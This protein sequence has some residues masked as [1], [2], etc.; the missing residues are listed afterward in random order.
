MIKNVLR[1]FIDSSDSTKHIDIFS[2]LVTQ[3]PKHSLLDSLYIYRH[4]KNQYGYILQDKNTQKIIAIDCG[5]YKTQRFNIE[6]LM[7]ETGG[8]FTHLFFTSKNSVRSEG[9]YD[10]LKVHPRLNIIKAGS[11]EDGHIEFIGD[12]CIF[13]M[14]T[15]GQNDLDTSYVI[16]EGNEGSTKTPAVFT[17][18][19]LQTGGCGKFLNPTLMYESLKKLKSLPNE[20][21][22]FPSVESAAENLMFSKIIDP[23]NE[24]VKSKL[25]EVK[26]QKRKNIGQVLCQERLYNPFLRCDQKYFLD[27]FEVKDPISC[28]TKMNKMK[29]KIL[30]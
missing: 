7:K 5:D 22:I 10:W 28:L 11:K 18:D 19:V 3:V 25:E 2:A 12:L 14:R 24:F 30:A 21:L 1:K 27:L 4:N 8:A 13:C 26:E 29:E 20:T 9:T 6:A 17:G 16:T 23:N 15:P